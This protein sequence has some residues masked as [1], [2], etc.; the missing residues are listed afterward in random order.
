MK[1]ISKIWATAAMLMLSATSI[2][3]ISKVE[4][5]ATGLTCS[6]C[7]NAIN[8]QLKTL[9][10]VTKVDTDLDKSTFV[11]Q[12]KNPNNL[13]PKHFNDKVEKAG[14]SVGSMVVTA[15]SSIVVTAPYQAI[16]NPIT[17]ATLHRIKILD[18]GYVSTKEFKNTAA[19]K[20]LRDK[21]ETLFHFQYLD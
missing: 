18:K 21:N 15:A 3:Q 16:N 14:F 8:K 12:L 10:E 5:I 11:I 17:T 19:K 9:P 20:S 2:A 4:I 6:M 1:S 13:T 7:S